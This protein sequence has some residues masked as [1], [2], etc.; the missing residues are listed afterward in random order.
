MSAAPCPA[1]GCRVNGSIAMPAT[2]LFSA[3]LTESEAALRVFL[4]AA[5][6][7]LAG[8]LL[9][10]LTIRWWRSTRPEPPALGPLEVMGDRKWSASAESER[11]R[12]I[13]EFRPVGA[14]PSNRFVEP[15][16]I[17][18]SVLARDAPATFDDL[19]EPMDDPEALE[20]ATAAALHAEPVDLGEP[21]RVDEADEPVDL[22]EPAVMNET[23]EPVELGEPEL[24]DEAVEPGVMD[25]AVDETVAMTTPAAQPLPAPSGARESSDLD[26]DQ[27]VRHGLGETEAM[28]SPEQPVSPSAGT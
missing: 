18:L 11:R 9:L 22:G 19:R 17:D 3:E 2:G 16:P 15:E 4:A 24:V 12:L 21:E 6:L 28:L 25:E 7:V 13:E 8:F 27:D 1:G 5:G 20:V 26:H 10:L 14:E 23:V